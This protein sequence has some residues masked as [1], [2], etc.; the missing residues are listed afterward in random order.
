MA[1]IVIV[2]CQPFDWKLPGGRDGV[3]LTK[4][5]DMIEGFGLTVNKKVPLLLLPIPLSSWDGD[6]RFRY[7]V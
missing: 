6:S 1:S 5:L 4:E 3:L 2:I 7:Q